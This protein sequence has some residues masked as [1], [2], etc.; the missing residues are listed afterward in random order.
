MSEKIAEKLENLKKGIRAVNNELPE[1]MEAWRSLHSNGMTSDFLPD[2]TIEL[3][4]V[5]IALSLRCTNCLLLHVQASKRSGASRAEILAVYETAL[6]MG[7]GPVMT[8]CAD[9]FEIL[10]HFYPPEKEEKK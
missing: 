7:G 1:T 6:V 2:K 9:L 4:A 10:D 5:G 3:I 8:Q